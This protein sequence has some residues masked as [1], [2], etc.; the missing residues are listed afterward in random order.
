MAGMGPPWQISVC[1]FSCLLL[2]EELMKHAV[3]VTPSPKRCDG[4]LPPAPPL[5]APCCPQTSE[6]QDPLGTEC[7]DPT[8]G[9][10][11]PPAPWVSKDQVLGR[12]A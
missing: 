12:E 6:C 2:E 8:W 4:R 7:Q 5:T 9:Q 1:A 11:L 3:I 10:R